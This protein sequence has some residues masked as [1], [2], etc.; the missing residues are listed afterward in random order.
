VGLFATKL[1][2]RDCNRSFIESFP[3]ISLGRP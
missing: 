2:Y 3:M 1:A